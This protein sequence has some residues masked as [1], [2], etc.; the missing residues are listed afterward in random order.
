MTAFRTG[1]TKLYS[2]KGRSNGCRE[3]QSLKNGNKV[4]P[5]AF[6]QVVCF[7]IA[8]VQHHVVDGILEKEQ[9]KEGLFYVAK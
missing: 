3:E 9:I 1:K 5:T 2:K 8:P 6:P 7:S 4:L